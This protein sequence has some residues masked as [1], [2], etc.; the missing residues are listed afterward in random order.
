MKT[1]L[2]SISVI[3]NGQRGGF[4]VE[5]RHL[6]DDCDEFVNYNL[7]VFSIEGVEK[8]IANFRREYSL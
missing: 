8:A 5:I 7:W 2:S 1:L 4:D 6:P 3:S